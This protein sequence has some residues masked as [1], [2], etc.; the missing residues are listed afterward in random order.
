MQNEPRDLAIVHV[1]PTRYTK[2]SLNIGSVDTR[3]TPNDL[4]ALPS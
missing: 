4:N 3:T 2:W 1:P